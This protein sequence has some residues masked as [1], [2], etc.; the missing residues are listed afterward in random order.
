MFPEDTFEN[1]ISDHEARE[2]LSQGVTAL[3]S[4]PKLSSV[5]ADARKHVEALECTQGLLD[6]CMSNIN[7][8]CTHSNGPHRT[9]FSQA[10]APTLV[11]E[12]ETVLKRLLCASCVTSASHINT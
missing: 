9:Y 10:I 12:L 5:E 8:M 7:R 3:H 1:D 4:L 2:T 11:L 6:V